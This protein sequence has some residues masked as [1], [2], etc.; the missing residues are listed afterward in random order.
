MSY[1]NKARL[2]DAQLENVQCLSFTF[3]HKPIEI[4]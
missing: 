2:E 4:P 1:G 3:L